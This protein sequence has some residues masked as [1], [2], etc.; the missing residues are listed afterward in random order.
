MSEICEH[1]SIYYR[2]KPKEIEKPHIEVAPKE[3]RKVRADEDIVK[4]MNV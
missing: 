1:F 3:D 4:C 2:L